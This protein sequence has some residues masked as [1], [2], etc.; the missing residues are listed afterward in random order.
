VAQTH[1]DFAELTGLYV[2]GGLTEGERKAFEAHA[3]SCATCTAEI[4]ALTPVPGALAHLARPESPSSDVRQ[5]IMASLRQ[6]GSVK[7]EREASAGRFHDRPAPRGGSLV[8]WLAAAASLALAV[9]LGGYALQLRR[10]ASVERL[11][12]SVLAAPD[13]VRIDLAGQQVAPSA[14]GR[15]FWS[16]SEGLVFTASNL[17]AAPAG[18]GYQVWVLSSQPAP[19]SAGM[20]K[21]DVNGRL[22]T[23]IKTP[24]DMAQPVAMAVTL[25]PQGGVAAPTGEKYLVGLAN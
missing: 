12:S 1:D 7:M 9:A 22:S 4:R 2:L 20:L 3:S 21:S 16:R 10:E 8:A 25:E 6:Q 19:M 11:A 5:R 23:T 18:R 13:L 14:S 17:P 24:V 15:A